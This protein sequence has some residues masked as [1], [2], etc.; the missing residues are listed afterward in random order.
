[1]GAYGPGH[2]PLAFPKIPSI[3]VAAS[4]TVSAMACR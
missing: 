4:L 3:A 1:M 2:V